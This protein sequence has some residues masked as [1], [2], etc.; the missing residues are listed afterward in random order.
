VPA[1]TIADNIYG[2]LVSRGK[3][4]RTVASQEGQDHATLLRSS[5]AIAAAVVAAAALAAGSWQPAA[6]QGAVPCTAIE[7]DAER[8]ACYDRALRPAPAA[9]AARPSASPAAPAQAAAAPAQAAAAPAA[10]AAP[11]ATEVAPRGERTVRQSAAPAAP[12]APVA[13][14]ATTT[15]DVI[16]IVIVGVRTLPGRETIFTAE[17]GA[18]WVQSDSQQIMGLP[19]APFEAEIQPGA[20]GSRF[21]RPKDFPRR[22]RVRSASR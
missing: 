4:M 18:T 6:A 21:L 10:I 17:D 13:G 12:A 7:D 14:A 20:M 22:I 9:P 1:A 5:A 3:I 19:D 11:A 16:P 8:L 2:I 15:N